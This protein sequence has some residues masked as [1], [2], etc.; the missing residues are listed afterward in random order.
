MKKDQDLS[1]EE[2]EKIP[3]N[4]DKK[5]IHTPWRDSIY[6]LWNHLFYDVGNFLVNAYDVGHFKLPNQD[7]FALQFPRPQDNEDSENVRVLTKVWETEVILL[8]AYLAP[9]MAVRVETYSLGEEGG[10]VRNVV[11]LRGKFT[12]DKPDQAWYIT[13]GL[14]TRFYIEGEVDKDSDGLAA[15]MVYGKIEG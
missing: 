7:V 15:F 4:P 6:Y 2:R 8:P 13:K 14:E 9:G 1:D 3:L 10:V 11:K 5:T 12:H